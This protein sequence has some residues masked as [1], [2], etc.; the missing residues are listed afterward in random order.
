VAEPGLLE[1]FVRPLH[2]AGI[3]YFVTGGVATIV[4]GEPRFTRDID[5]VLS[6]RP[7]DA[8]RFL[9]L[10]PAGE[11]YAPPKE[12]FE[13][14]SARHAHGHFNL[15]H[16]ETALTADCYVAG[17]DPLHAWAFERV[18]TLDVDGLP[19]RMAPVEYVILRKLSYFAQS[20]STR[21]LEDVA[22]MRRVQ[23]AAVDEAAIGEWTRALGLEAAWRVARESA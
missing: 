20:G 7:A 22:R 23:G 17:N 12:A 8:D 11:F 15:V 1:L 5:L 3:D 4:Y 13:T 18:R 16:V 19:V 10:W 9:A 6:V 2:G 14:E 21:H